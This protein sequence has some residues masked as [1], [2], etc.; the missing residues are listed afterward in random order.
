MSRSDHICLMAEYNEWMNTKLYEAASSL[1]GEE[2]I[3]D[4]K[5]FFGSILGT[6]N[7]L[8]VGDTLWL[9]R[10]ATHP[11]DFPALAMI[12]NL[13]TPTSLD[14]L[15]Y[16]D[17]QSLSKHRKTLDSAIMDWTRSLTDR[18]LDFVL[19][20]ANMKGIA[21]RKRFFSL[22][23]HFSTIKHTTAVN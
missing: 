16:T 11:A 14:Q 22:V 9:K 1:P 19:P 7:H 6:L 8:V 5:A 3:A 12:R 17:I 15:I 23:I 4:R 18:D 10:F 2:L 20:Y 21:A 13:P